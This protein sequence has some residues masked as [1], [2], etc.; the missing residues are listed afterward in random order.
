MFKY[1]LF[2]AIATIACPTMAKMDT[3]PIDYICFGF[4]SSGSVGSE[5]FKIQAEAMKE[6]VSNLEGTKTQFAAYS[7]VDRVHRA[8]DVTNEAIEYVKPFSSNE[9]FQSVDFVRD[10]TISNQYDDISTAIIACGDALKKVSGVRLMILLTDGYSAPYDKLLVYQGHLDY[11]RSYDGISI[12]TIGT[13]S[14]PNDDLLSEVSSSPDFYETTE[15]LE[16]ISSTVISLLSKPSICDTIVSTP[17]PTPD[18]SE[19]KCRPKSCKFKLSPSGA[20]IARGRPFRVGIVGGT[21]EAYVVHNKKTFRI[22]KWKPMGIR[23][24]FSP[25]FFKAF[26]MGSGYTSGVGFETPQTNQD[27]YIHNTRVC[28]PIRAYQVLSG[29]KLPRVIDNVNTREANDCIFFKAQYP[30]TFDEA[31]H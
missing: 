13:G 16:S 27:E 10:D 3:C 29:G 31:T 6:I 11:A 19:F 18:N 14:S 15:D 2:L 7:M 30:K 20:I 23:Q 4:D 5:G 21:G 22:S 1:L 8:F 17:T 24:R 28:L 12:V 26:A 9:E 25:S